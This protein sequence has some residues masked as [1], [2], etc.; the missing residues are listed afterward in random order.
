MTEFSTDER[1]EAVL[2][3]D[4]GADGRFWY[5]VK[6]TGVYCRPGCPSRRPRR[7]NVTFHDSP[8]QAEAAGYQA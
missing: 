3:H 7:D 5:G 2:A 1:W 6:T 8:Q 4:A